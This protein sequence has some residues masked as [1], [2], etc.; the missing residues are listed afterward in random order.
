MILLRRFF[1]SELA[2]RTNA[3]GGIR[4][5]SGRVSPGQFESLMW[6]QHESAYV[7]ERQTPLPAITGA[8]YTRTG[9]R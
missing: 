3:N 2:T 5:P 6:R 4:M 9:T 8:D 1:Y 7:N